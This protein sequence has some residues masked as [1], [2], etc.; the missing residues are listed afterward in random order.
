MRFI[1]HHHYYFEE[2]KI[3]LMPSIFG[4]RLF[5]NF[6]DDFD[7]PVWNSKSTAGA[8]SMRTDVKETENGY[9]LDID[10][11]GFKKEDVKA[12]LKNGYLTIN[13][14]T[15]NNNDQ[16]DENGKYIRRERFYGSMSRSFY[17]GENVT[18]DDIHAKFSDGILRLTVPKKTKEIPQDKYISIEG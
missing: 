2:E 15:N 17:V 12:Q 7:F 9:E 4:E 14:T 8:H 3:M 6:M 18:E 13:A 1:S 11:P 5:D 10:L 16:K